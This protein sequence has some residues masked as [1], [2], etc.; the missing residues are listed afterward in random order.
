MPGLHVNLERSTDPTSGWVTNTSFIATEVQTNLVVEMSNS[1]D[2][3]FYRIKI[4]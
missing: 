3:L 4:E 1:Q 2:R